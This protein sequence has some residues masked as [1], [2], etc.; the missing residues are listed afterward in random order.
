MLL[1]TAVKGAKVLVIHIGF[2]KTKFNLCLLKISN[3]LD[4]FNFLVLYA[5]LPAKVGERDQKR[6][7]YKGQ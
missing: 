5:V 2:A 7:G 1:G 4:I 3:R 6:K